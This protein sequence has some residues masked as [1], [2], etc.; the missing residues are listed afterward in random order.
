[1]I[2]MANLTCRQCGMSLDEDVNNLDRYCP[3]CGAKLFIT[4]GQVIDI[5]DDRKE[6]KR[7]DVKYSTQI[8]K[9]SDEKKSQK[10]KQDFVQTFAVIGAIAVILM[11]VVLIGYFI[12]GF[13][14]TG[15]EV[16][17]PPIK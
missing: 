15:S 9:V 1:M 6:L 4:V 12:A 14:V 8:H 10:Q 2:R 13:Y 3:N 5:L 11:T 16:T 17:M 7:K